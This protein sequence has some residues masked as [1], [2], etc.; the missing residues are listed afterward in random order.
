MKIKKFY[1]IKVKEYIKDDINT[2]YF[3]IGYFDK[4]EAWVGEDG[5]KGI[6]YYLGTVSDKKYVKGYTYKGWAEKKIKEIHRLTKS[7]EYFYPYE[8]N[9]YKYQFEIVEE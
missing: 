8:D 2:G 4:L 5:F 9:V 6:K 3:D 1:Y 7:L